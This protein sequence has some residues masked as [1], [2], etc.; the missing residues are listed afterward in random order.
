MRSGT[1]AK[2]AT[3]NWSVF[4]GTQCLYIRF[5]GSLCLPWYVRNTAWS[6]KKSIPIKHP[7]TR[8]NGY[9]NCT[10]KKRQILPL[11]VSI[12][13]LWIIHHSSYFLY[14]LNGFILLKLIIFNYTKYNNY[15]LSFRFLF[16]LTPFL[17]FSRAR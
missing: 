1:K 4:L 5:P 6:R 3:T 14:L 11:C 10:C 7:S 16:Y 17:V 2:S 15:Y 9:K 12:N 8:L 13:T